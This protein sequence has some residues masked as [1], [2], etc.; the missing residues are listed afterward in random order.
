MATRADTAVPDAARPV[1]RYDAF[2]SY[3]H[4]GDD[5]LAPALQAGLHRFAKPWY[6]L[7]SLRVFRDDASLSADPALWVAIERALASSEWF[8][9]L[10]SPEAARSEWVEKEVAWWLSHRGPARLLVI[11][12]AGELAWNAD[13]DG[14]DGARTTALPASA[15]TGLAL[16]PRWVDLRWAQSADDVSLANAR[17]R[18]AVAEVAA[19]VLGQPKDELLGEDVRQHRRTKRVVRAAITTLSAFLLAA[20]AAAVVA[21]DQRRD[22]ISQ[23]DRAVREATIARAQA[24]AAQAQLSLETTSLSAELGTARPDRA[25]LLAIE[26]LRMSPTLEADQALRNSLAKLQEPAIPDWARQHP[27]RGPGIDPPH[28]A[29]EVNSP[30]RRWRARAPQNPGD[31]VVLEES[32]GG[33]KRALAHEWFLQA[34]RF[35][36][37]S[38]WL[39][40]VTMPVSMDAQDP[41]ATVLVGSTIRVWDV[42][43]GREQTRVSLAKEGGIWETLFSPDGN[44]LATY[45]RDARPRLW[46]LWP[47]RLEAEAC[48]RLRRNLSPSEWAEF[49]GDG[50]RRDTCPGLPV[51]SE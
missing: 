8:L 37:D 11:L 4:A 19:S 12:T 15:L 30:S 44:M 9:L 45:G 18:D 36:P 10:A 49:I 6:R 47:P 33:E 13:G 23:R 25:A 40:T 38:R 17:F 28:P 50:P 51:V 26:S 14:V 42:A 29:A 32:H 21:I 43:T 16:E 31:P 22:A 41:G 27:W 46:V 7:R 2:L 48:R 39:A 24:L 34:I 5:R 3:S 20:V 35:S 1:P